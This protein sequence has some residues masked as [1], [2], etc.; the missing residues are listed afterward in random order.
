MLLLHRFVSQAIL[1]SKHSQEPSLSAIG[2]LH[3]CGALR[4]VRLAAQKKVRNEV[5]V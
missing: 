4:G 2:L 5:R 3:L 1:Y